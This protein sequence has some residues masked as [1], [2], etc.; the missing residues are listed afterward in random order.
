MR[1]P[2]EVH[3]KLKVL[4]ADQEEN[5]ENVE[6]KI[7]TLNSENDANAW[8]KL[9]ISQRSRKRK[10]LVPRVPKIKQKNN[11]NYVSQ[12]TNKEGGT[13][14]TVLCANCQRRQGIGTNKKHDAEDGI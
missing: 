2:L 4:E 14:S 1:K 13:Q 12:K 8:P 3:N 10:M 5:D 11:P 6:D 9:D 7:V